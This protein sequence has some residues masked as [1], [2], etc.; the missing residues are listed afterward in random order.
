MPC[1]NHSKYLVQSILS[2]QTQTL[3][4]IE[5]IIVDDCSTDD[6]MRKINAIA[7]TDAR[8]KVLQ[9]QKNKGA[10]ASRNDG[11]RLAR[12]HFIGF[13]DA[14]DVWLPGKLESQIKLLNDNP[15]FSVAYS[16][17]E[18]IDKDGCATGELFSDQFPLPPNPSG[19]IFHY[20]CMRNF[21]NMQT[22][23]IRRDSISDDLLFDESIKWVEDWWQ[24]IRLSYRHKFIYDR[25]PQ[26][27]YRVHPTST[28][29]TQKS[30]ISRNRWRVCK[31][32]L[33]LHRDVSN[34]IRSRLW[35][36]MALELSSMNWHRTSSRNILRAIKYA[37]QTPRSFHHIFPMLYYLAV[38]YRYMVSKGL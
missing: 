24:W 16:D 18:I 34:L 27:Q 7:S 2:I 38:Q 4:D 20:L 5:L 13:C 8:I 32:N 14:D 29:F 25:R 21:I 26:S 35:Y 28:G 19:T 15:F 23:V 36:I 9:H 17:S 11:I 31:R 33:R 30:G 10:S 12:G 37:V 1:F 3:S 22:V 6:S